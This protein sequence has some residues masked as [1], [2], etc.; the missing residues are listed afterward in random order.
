[1]TGINIGL[2]DRVRGRAD[3]RSARCKV[4]RIRRSASPKYR[5]WIGYRYPVKRS[6]TVICRRYR[7]V[8]DI[9]DV[10]VVHFGRRLV[11]PRRVEPTRLSLR[12]LC[13]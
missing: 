12:S 4:R 9:A 6:I 7:V 1:M 3:D 13:D 10:T 8:N 5:I 2:R 11:D